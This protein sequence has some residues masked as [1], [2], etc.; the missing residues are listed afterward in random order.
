MAVDGTSW[1]RGSSPLKGALLGLLLQHPGHGYD[2]AL[3]L[4]RRLGPAWQ[5]EAKGLY[6]MLAQLERGDER[7]SDPHG[8]GPFDVI[9]VEKQNE[10]PPAR[11]AR[12]RVIRSSRNAELIAYVKPLK[13]FTLP[14]VS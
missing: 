12:A 7:P 3:R 11:S 9:D 6:P 4:H 8:S 13:G 2:L 14:T 5:I 1:M 10:H